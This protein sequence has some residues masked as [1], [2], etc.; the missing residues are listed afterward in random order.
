MD[1]PPEPSAV[2]RPVNRGELAALPQRPNLPLPSA[3][4]AL[5]AERR[6]AQTAARRTQAVFPPT[7]NSHDRPSAVHGPARAAERPPAPAGRRRAGQPPA[8]GLRPQRAVFHLH[9]ALDAA[10]QT[11]GAP[12][13]VLEAINVTL[14]SGVVVPPFR[15]EVGLRRRSRPGRPSASGRR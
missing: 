2:P 7:C 15:L 5:N 13:E 6:A 4:G 8:P 1:T 10:A 3:A 11:T 14:P 9:M 12:I